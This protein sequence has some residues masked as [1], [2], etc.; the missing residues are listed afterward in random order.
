MPFSNNLQHCE[1]AREYHKALRP[2]LYH[3]LCLKSTPCITAP[4]RETNLFAY[5]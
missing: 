2:L 5:C 4:L 1:V 3:S